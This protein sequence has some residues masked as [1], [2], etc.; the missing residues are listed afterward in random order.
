MNKINE[1]SDNIKI[2]ESWLLKQSSSIEIKNKVQMTLRKETYVKVPKYLNAQSSP[3]TVNDNKPTDD[4][5]DSLSPKQN[6][7]NI[8][9]PQSEFSILMNDI[10]FTP[11]KNTKTLRND[12][13]KFLPNCCSTSDKSDR[14][15]SFSDDLVTHSESKNATFD[16]GSINSS[17]INNTYELPISPTSSKT[18]SHL[19]PTCLAKSFDQNNLDIG[20]STPLQVNSNFN[21]SYEHTRF[22]NQ[23]SKSQVDF[24]SAKDCLE[25]DLWVKSKNTSLSPISKNLMHST[26]DSITEEDGHIH[27]EDKQFNLNNL[28]TELRTKA[29]CIE[30]SPPKQHKGKSSIRKVSPTKNSKI[31]K[32]RSFVE[33]VNSK[34]K[35]QINQSIKSKLVTNFI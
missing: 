14:S 12:N 1:F 18:S 33:K 20:F 8:G 5:D 17:K 15:K 27:D 30:I 9:I 4:F 28:Q 13:L 11:F 7:I 32:G 24:G 34:K 25:A 2:N 21:V 22:S 35:I 26:L 19:K 10:K 3:E 31:I 6:D 16:L 23:F 29:L